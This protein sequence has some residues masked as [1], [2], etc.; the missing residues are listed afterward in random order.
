M[1]RKIPVKHKPTVKK[2]FIFWAVFLLCV[3]FS[4]SS[5]KFDWSLFTQGVKKIPDIAV[6]LL[7][8]DFSIFPQVVDAMITTLAIAFIGIMISSFFG[9]VFGF[10]TAG[11]TTPS[12]LV[13]KI[14]SSICVL[15]RTVPITVWVLLAVASAGFGSTAAVLGITLPTTA[16]LTKTFANQIESCGKDLKEAMV[17]LG[18]AWPI[19]I[20]KGFFPMCKTSLLAVAAF[21][22]E[23]SVSESTVLG[24]IGCGGIGFMISKYIKVYKFEQAA[25][26]LLVVLAVMYL[27]EMCTSLLRKKIRRNENEAA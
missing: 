22:F 24:L 14:I 21:R 2:Q 3:V 23:M 4:Y 5:L 18:V 16:Y 11:N 17:S 8:V 12:K 6:K 19:M 25:L 9:L 7:T 15:V 26:C 1:R 20:V 13:H 10:L 27:L